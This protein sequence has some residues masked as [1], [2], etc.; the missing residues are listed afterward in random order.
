MSTITTVNL[1][2]KF[3]ENLPDEI[4]AWLN[5]NNFED[6]LDSDRYELVVPKYILENADRCSYLN[7]WREDECDYEY[8]PDTKLLTLYG[9]HKNK[10]ED[11]E[12]FVNYILPF[13]DTEQSLGFISNGYDS[14]VYKIM[15]TESEDPSIINKEVL[16]SRTGSG[17]DNQELYIDIEDNI[18][19]LEELY[20]EQTKF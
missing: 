12:K 8:N 15:F 10:D 20:Q 11:W 9:E 3:K 1:R 16:Q 17:Y 7:R 13:I 2:I 5:A 6:I 4:G 14:A 18:D 19:N